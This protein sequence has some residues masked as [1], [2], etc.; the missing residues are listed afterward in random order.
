MSHSFFN[1]DEPLLPRD[2]EIPFKFGARVSFRLKLPTENNGRLVRYLPKTM[3]GQTI[4]WNA[5][6]VHPFRWFVASNANDEEIHRV[7]YCFTTDV[8]VIDSRRFVEWGSIVDG[9]DEDDGWIKV[10][11]LPWLAK[12]SCQKLLEEG[13]WIRGLFT[14]FLLVNTDIFDIVPADATRHMD[15]IEL[16]EAAADWGVKFAGSPS[17]AELVAS[18]AEG[19]SE[20]DVL[21]QHI[22]QMVDFAR[23]GFVEK[24]MP[25][26]TEY[27]LKHGIRNLYAVEMLAT[28]ACYEFAVPHR[29]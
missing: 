13:A 29:R 16:E 23:Q 17:Q 6:G 25:T 21:P 19:I 14:N 9:I 10:W 8:T 27:A 24:V 20:K 3:D 4:L 2:D 1:P 11:Y 18:V 7:H 28:I 12:D 5:G 22:Y 15:A 26:H